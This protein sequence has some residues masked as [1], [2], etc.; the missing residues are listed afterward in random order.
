MV[1]KAVYS[2]SAASW[3]CS[4]MVSYRLSSTLA[5]RQPEGI[6]PKMRYKFSRGLTQ[7]DVYQTDIIQELAVFS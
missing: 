3:P 4:S 1:P 2:D 5:H 6:K 7:Q